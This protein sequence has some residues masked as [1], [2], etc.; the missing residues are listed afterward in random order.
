[1]LL[2]IHSHSI[3]KVWLCLRE[4]WVGCPIIAVAIGIKDLPVAANPREDLN[5]MATEVTG[6]DKQVE[7]WKVKKLIKNLQ[8][9]RGYVNPNKLQKLIN[10]MT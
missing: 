2:L 7:M 8:A 4:V 5:N 3:E 9:A 10:I 6:Q 1:M